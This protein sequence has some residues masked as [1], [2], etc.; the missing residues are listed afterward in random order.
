MDATGNALPHSPTFSMQMIWE[1]SFLLPNDATLTPRVSSHF[2]TSSWLSI[3]HDGS[4]DKQPAYTRTDFNMIY[5][6][7]GRKHYELEFYVQN[8]EDGDIR[9]NA[10]ATSDNIYTSQFLPPRTFGFNARYDF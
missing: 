3:L 1:H 4:G 9:T 5:R 7:P 2:E 8:I 10:L 6:A